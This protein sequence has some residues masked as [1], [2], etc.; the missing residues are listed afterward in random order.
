MRHGIRQSRQ[1]LSSPGLATA[2]F[3]QHLT[4]STMSC[5]DC[6]P[7]VAHFTL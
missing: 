3:K 1:P 2:E 7:V 6:Y 4:Q 5:W